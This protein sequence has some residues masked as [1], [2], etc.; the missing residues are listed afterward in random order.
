MDRGEFYRMQSAAMKQAIERGDDVIFQACFFDGTWLGFADFL[1]RTDDPD[2]PLGWSYEVADTK[3]AA[4]LEG[5]VVILEKELGPQVEYI[6]VLVLSHYAS[7]GTVLGLQGGDLDAT[8]S[9]GM[10]GGKAGGAGSH[11]YDLHL[12]PP[13]CVGSS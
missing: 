3:L 6:A 9:Q 1:L 12:L 5:G 8:F 4:E 2:A 13:C 11:Y 7:S 10:D